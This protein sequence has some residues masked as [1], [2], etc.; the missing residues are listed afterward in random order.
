MPLL[1]IEDIVRKLAAYYEEYLPAKLVSFEASYGDNVLLPKPAKILLDELELANL[2]SYPALYVFGSQT[3]FGRYSDTYADAD[4][5][6]DI[7]MLHMARDTN[8]PNLRIQMYRYMRALWECNI[9]R[10]TDQAF[11][12]F[13]STGQPQIN[14]IPVLTGDATAPYLM[15][16]RMTIVFNKQESYNG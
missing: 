11:Q 5:T 2:A 7:G 1:L 3:T 15:D 12:D 14:F 8:V 9:D 4:H 16:A 6:V 10:M 13:Y